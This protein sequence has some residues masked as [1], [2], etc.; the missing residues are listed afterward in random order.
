LS[1]TNDNVNTSEHI[2]SCWQIKMEGAKGFEPPDKEQ[3]EPMNSGI[4]M[5]TPRA[6]AQL[7]SQSSGSVCPELAQVVSAW[8]K[9]PKHVK[10]TILMI[11][12]AA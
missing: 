10:Q 4:P 8:A 6:H 9:L 11:I 1:N 12:S 5:K 2:V 3:K 7:A